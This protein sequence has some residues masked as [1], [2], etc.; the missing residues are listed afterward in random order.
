MDG[1]ACDPAWAA[2]QAVK[3]NAR[4]GAINQLPRGRIVARDS[5][6]AA[7]VNQTGAH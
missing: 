7:N 5:M 6:S 1:R 2:P 3:P 4:T